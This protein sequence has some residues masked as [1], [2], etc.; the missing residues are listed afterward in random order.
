MPLFIFSESSILEVGKDSEYASAVS[1]DH[2][3][4]NLSLGSHKKL[5]T[6]IA[7]FITFHV[8]LQWLEKYSENL[9]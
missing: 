6:R 4:V 7:K 2:L 5:I 9:L 1:R 8:I 3:L